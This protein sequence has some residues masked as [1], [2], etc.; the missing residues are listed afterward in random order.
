M[1]GEG[2]SKTGTAGAKVL[3]Q[4]WLVSL[5]KTARGLCWILRADLPRGAD[6]ELARPELT[7]EA[8]L[9]CKLSGPYILRHLPGPSEGLWLDQMFSPPPCIEEARDTLILSLS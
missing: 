4:E 7:V 2:H 6:T 1:P 8:L 5:D 3:R 9:T